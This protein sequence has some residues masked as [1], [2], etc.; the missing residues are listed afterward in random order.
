MA[1][2]FVIRQPVGEKWH[3]VEKELLVPLLWLR[4][5]M[6]LHNLVCTQT[7]DEMINGGKIGPQV[8]AEFALSYSSDGGWNYEWL[9]VWGSP[10][11]YT[12]W[13]ENAPMRIGWDGKCR[14]T[15]PACP[16]Q[17][18]GERSENS[19]PIIQL[20]EGKAAAE[21]EYN[22]SI[23]SYIRN[24]LPVRLLKLNPKSEDMKSDLL[25]Y[26]AGR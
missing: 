5:H 24:K 10:R 11:T 25:P 16:Y 12:V 26:R 4:V 18:I 3:V 20:P 13:D 19:W 1:P 9:S 17:I 22:R 2:Q 6:E 7:F 21:L 15:F 8:L 23:Y 14:M